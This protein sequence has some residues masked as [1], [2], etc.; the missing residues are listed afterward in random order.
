MPISNDKQGSDVLLL[1]F[2]CEGAQIRLM[3]TIHKEKQVILTHPLLTSISIIFIFLPFLIFPFYCIYESN[4]FL[5]MYGSCQA[6]VCGK[7]KD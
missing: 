2:A 6:V 4:L 5:L 7:Q 3:T 1:G